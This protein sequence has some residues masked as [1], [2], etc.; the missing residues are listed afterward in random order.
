MHYGDWVGIYAPVQLILG[1]SP[2]FA[3]QV[4]AAVAFADHSLNQL[5]K[6]GYLTSGA[7]TANATTIEEIPFDSAE[8][9]G[10]DVRYPSDMDTMIDAK[11][12]DH[13]GAED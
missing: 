6:V 5:R 12:E 13:S 8:W 2:D 1:D 11:L 4:E 10:R 3:S 9:V 7:T